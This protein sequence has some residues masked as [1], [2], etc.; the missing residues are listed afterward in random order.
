MD[1]E[2]EGWIRWYEHWTKGIKTKTLA[3]LVAM[4]AKYYHGHEDIPFIDFYDRYRHKPNQKV[5]R[6]VPEV[7]RELIENEKMSRRSAYDYAKV[8]QKI[9]FITR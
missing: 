3:R 2:I 1:A 9:Q 6:T 7:V 8:I 4:V 5:L